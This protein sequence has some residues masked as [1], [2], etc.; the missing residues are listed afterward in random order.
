MITIYS[1]SWCA[2]CHAVTDYL[3][4]F[5]IKYVVIDIEKDSS[6]AKDMIDK[7]GQMGVPVVDIDGTI[8]VGFDRSRINSTLKDK[9]LI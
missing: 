3:D 6:A 4:K 7:S 8:I 1:T 2:Y 5:G 9:K